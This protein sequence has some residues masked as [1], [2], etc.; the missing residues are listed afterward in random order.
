MKLNSK[1]FITGHNGLVGNSIFHH[2]KKKKFKN[3]FVV[4]KKKLDLRDQEKF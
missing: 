2:L 3:I 4:N 1:I